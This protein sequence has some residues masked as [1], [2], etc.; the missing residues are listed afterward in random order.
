MGHT[1]YCGYANSLPS[2]KASSSQ[3]VL[4]VATIGGLRLQI[5]ELQTEDY[6]AWKIWKQDL[7]EVWEDIDGVLYQKSL[8]YIQEIIRTKLISKKH[9]NSLAGHFGINKT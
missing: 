9:D 5:P 7:K 6:E 1:S 3:R 2:S 4:S 8:L